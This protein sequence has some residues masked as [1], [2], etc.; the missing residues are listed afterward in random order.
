MVRGDFI[1]LLRWL[2]VHV[3]R[4]GQT[5]RGHALVAAIL[6]REPGPGTLVE[7]LRHKN[8]LLKEL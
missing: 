2:R 3:H 4:L 5:Y 7:H 8:R 1:E 6:G